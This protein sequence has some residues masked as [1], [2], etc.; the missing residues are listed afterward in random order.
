[1]TQGAD[2]TFRVNLKWMATQFLGR[3]SALADKGEV[4]AFID[5]PRYCG[6]DAATWGLLWLLR[7]ATRAELIVEGLNDEEAGRL[8]ELLSQVLGIGPP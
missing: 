4:C 7:F 1:M 3:N 5:R 2:H 6:R 8:I